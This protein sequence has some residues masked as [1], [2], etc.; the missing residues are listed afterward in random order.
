ML[1]REDRGAV[2]VVVLLATVGLPA[3]RLY[4]AAWRQQAGAQQLI[5][6]QAKEQGT[7]A[8]LQNLRSVQT[9]PVEA[10]RDYGRVI[11]QTDDHRCNYLIAG[12]NEKQ[13]AA[14]K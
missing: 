5:A 12:A 2:S 1:V 3:M 10:R 7:E 11:Q 8:R 13:G 6:Q 4:Y 9:G 14:R